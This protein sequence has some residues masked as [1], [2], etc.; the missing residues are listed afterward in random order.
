MAN[1]RQIFFALT[2]RSWR[3]PLLAKHEYTVQS[4]VEGMCFDRDFGWWY[5]CLFIHLNPVSRTALSVC[6]FISLS[7]TRR[8][9][10]QGRNKGNKGREARTNDERARG[11]AKNKLCNLFVLRRRTSGAAP[12]DKALPD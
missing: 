12:S 2:R 11:G 5:F 7:K 9:A 8:K 3:K 4:I 10:N 6:Q 1:F